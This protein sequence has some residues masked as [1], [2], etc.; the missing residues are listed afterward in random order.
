MRMTTSPEANAWAPNEEARLEQKQTEEQE[1]VATTR[2]RKVFDFALENALGTPEIL[3]EIVAFS[4]RFK[5]AFPKDWERYKLYH[6]FIRSGV[7]Q[8]SDLFDVEGEQAEKFSVLRFA[9]TLAER[10]NIRLSE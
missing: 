1:R 7:T 4:E 3:E 10:F 5:T 6:F 8:Q 2:V 9:E